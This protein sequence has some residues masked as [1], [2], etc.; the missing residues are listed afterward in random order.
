MVLLEL[1]EINIEKSTSG[2]YNIEIIFFK[3][4]LINLLLISKTLE[5]VI[6]SDVKN[7]L[8]LRY[9]YFGEDGIGLQ[10]K[11]I[12]IGSV[13]EHITGFVVQKSKIYQNYKS[14]FV[15]YNIVSYYLNSI[16]KSENF[17]KMG[18]NYDFSQ[19]HESFIGIVN[20]TE[21]YIEYRP[22]ILLN[23]T[24]IKRNIELNNLI[25]FPKKN[26]VIGF[27]NNFD[28]KSF[29]Y[30]PLLKPVPN[31]E[32]FSKNLDENTD[33]ILSF[34]NN[35]YFSIDSLELN[36]EISEVFVKVRPLRITKKDVNDDDVDKFENVLFKFECDNL[37]YKTDYNEFGNYNLKINIITIRFINNFSTQQNNN[38]ILI[39]KFT[40][41]TIETIYLNEREANIYYT[42][43]YEW[44]ENLP[45]FTKDS[46]LNLKIAGIKE[47]RLKE[48]T[49]N[50][51]IKLK[52]LVI[53]KN[54]SV[55][56]VYLHIPSS[57]R[58][59]INKNTDNYDE[60]ILKNNIIEIIPKAKE[61]T[62][63]LDGLIGVK[64]I[65]SNID[66]FNNIIINDIDVKVAGV[67][68]NINKILINLNR[69]YPGD[70]NFNSQIN[71][72]TN[73]VIYS[74]FLK[75]SAVNDDF[76][77][78]LSVVDNLEFINL[79]GDPDILA[80]KNPKIINLDQIVTRT[81]K[82][83]IFEDE[84]EINFKIERTTYDDKSLSDFMVDT[85]LVSSFNPDIIGTE[86]EKLY[87]DLSDKSCLRKTIK[88][89]KD[90]SCFNELLNPETF[91]PYANY[92]R[93]H[94]PG[95]AN[96]F[97]EL[98]IPNRFKRNELGLSN[99]N[100]TI[101][102]KIVEVNKKN[103]IVKNCKIIIKSLK[104]LHHGE[105][106]V[107]TIV[108]NDKNSGLLE[109]DNDNFYDP[110]LVKPRIDLSLNLIDS[111]YYTYFTY[112]DNIFNNINFT[113]VDDSLFGIDCSNT[114]VFIGDN[115]IISENSYSFYE[116]AFY[117]RNSNIID[118]IIRIGISNANING[119]YNSDLFEIK[120]GTL[121]LL[122]YPKNFPN[123]EKKISY[124]S[125]LNNTKYN[126]YV[127]SKF[128]QSNT[129]VLSY[130]LVKYSNNNTY[131]T[132]NFIES[133]M[134]DSSLKLNEH[135][136]NTNYNGSTL[137]DVYLL[138]YIKT[139]QLYIC[140]VIIKENDSGIIEYFD[141]ILSSEMVTS[142]TSIINS[143]NS[144][145]ILE[146]YKSTSEISTNIGDINTKL[147]YNQNNDNVKLGYIRKKFNFIP[148]VMSDDKIIQ[149]SDIILFQPISLYYDKE[150]HTQEQNEYIIAFFDSESNKQYIKFFKII[151]KKEEPFF[152]NI[153]N[154]S[155]AKIINNPEMSDIWYPG[156]K[157]GLF[158]TKPIDLINIYNNR[159]NFVLFVNSEEDT[160][161]NT[162]HDYMILNNF[163]LPLMDSNKY[164]D[165]S[166]EYRYLR[167]NYDDARIEVRL[168]RKNKEN[169]NNPIQINGTVVIRE[170]EYESYYNSLSR[171][172][173]FFDVDVSGQIIVNLPG[174]FN[175]GT[176]NYTIETP[177]VL[178]YQVAN[179]LD[180]STFLKKI[181]ESKK[182]F[183]FTKLTP[184]EINTYQKKNKTVLNVRKFTTPLRLNDS[185]TEEHKQNFQTFLSN[186]KTNTNI[187]KQTK[188]ITERIK[189]Q[190]RS[191][192]IDSLTKTGIGSIR[193]Y[194]QEI[195]QSLEVDI[196]S[197]YTGIYGDDILFNVV[198]VGIIENIRT[199]IQN[200]KDV[201]LDWDYINDNL[202]VQVLFILYRSQEGGT[203]KNYVEIGRTT[204]RFFRDS[205]AIP[206][207]QAF[208]KIE[209]I[210]Q[211]EGIEMSTGVNYTETFICE[212]NNFEYGRYNNT[213]ENPKLYQPINKSCAKIKMV[214]ITKTGNLF[215]NSVTLTKK[216]LYTEL[217]R[218]KFRPFR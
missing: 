47:E 146:K 49:N 15:A 211:W 24:N 112:N 132:N 195:N 82:V 122:Q 64:V 73:E 10:T 57:N 178:S 35:N 100:P 86:A 209:S 162:P 124:T 136:L 177:Y 155:N 46:F 165:F 32:V 90:P 29:S 110:D 171:N 42:K 193:Y 186:N 87:F 44:G 72:L 143:A 127:T 163:D 88:F 116:L 189:F 7:N 130:I 75:I 169:I 133:D 199:K 184:G 205:G 92:S 43:Q 95:E 40:N 63:G 139:N 142:S 58:Y 168:Y 4:K 5:S 41:N 119:V 98:S 61:N 54:E 201:R 23:S 38:K 26:V 157:F 197:A 34:E 48:F 212:N 14:G 172:D 135:N 6:F 60:I 78:R 39:N 121:S 207:L 206:F 69:P 62:N 28:N 170:S 51:D 204:N 3:N 217:S 68:S 151:L 160:V 159:E 208:Y 123:T 102:F 12:E 55:L 161:I 76:F 105:I 2:R 19:K 18:Y 213:T 147:Y 180:N 66:L 85:E 113:D 164:S 152:I 174:D 17:F 27:K 179:H 103:K 183:N 144:L 111:N 198:N 1:N 154:S 101:Y 140:L 79:D 65:E 11:T 80:G 56:D 167:R 22:K 30:I 115:M 176:G 109:Y 21:N 25:Y 117:L 214:G 107:T 181:V 202:T 210:I 108:P 166:I 125:S 52:I 191:I 36:E 81:Y 194:T 150:N 9:L 8:N 96:G 134:I 53:N 200:E 50:I 59:K 77:N 89:Y 156:T 104:R 45:L 97:V 31:I 114:N 145:T 137:N 20:K 128:A 91:L 16:W 141:K 215:P 148:E 153:G 196:S 129:P 71:Y 175:L 185:E 173:V 120:S 93:D 99:D 182:F 106:S 192:D 158:K 216:A 131:N 149:G 74:D 83:K 13:L 94:I 190:D 118:G 126:V 37:F 203:N 84:E 67:Q 70:I 138:A 218:A 33:Q 187:N 188:L